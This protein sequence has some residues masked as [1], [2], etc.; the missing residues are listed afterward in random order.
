METVSLKITKNL[1]RETRHA[2]DLLGLDFIRKGFKT[3]ID[4]EDFERLEI[5]AQENPRVTFQPNENKS[6]T[7]PFAWFEQIEN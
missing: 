7:V 5:E 6:Y 3:E 1:S 2:L 4:L